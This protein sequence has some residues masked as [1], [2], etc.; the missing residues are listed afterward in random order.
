MSQ[1]LQYLTNEH[2]DRTSVVLPIRDYEK[3]LEDLEDLAVVVERRNDLV[4]A[5][6]DFVSDLKR[7][8]IL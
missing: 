1:Y 3:F 4:I 2:G 5:N 6:E 7:D 8:D